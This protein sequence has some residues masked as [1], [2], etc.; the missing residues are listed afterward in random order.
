MFLRP[1]DRDLVLGWRAFSCEI[2]PFQSVSKN[3]KSKRTDNIMQTIKYMFADGTTSEIEV[4]GACYKRF[5][6]K[7]HLFVKKRQKAHSNA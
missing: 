1:S 3:K 7:F 6:K 5:S 2:C 4:S